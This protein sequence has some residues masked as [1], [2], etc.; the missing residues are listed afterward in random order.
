MDVRSRFP[1]G[2]SAIVVI[3]LKEALWNYVLSNPLIDS[4]EMKEIEQR[5]H[6]FNKIIKRRTIPIN[7][8]L[9]IRSEYKNGTS[10]ELLSKR[11]KLPKRVIIRC[12]KFNNQ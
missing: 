7:Q 5:L 8:A 6:E 12:I 10:I 11:Y 2:R 4:I 1:K 9:F 3:N